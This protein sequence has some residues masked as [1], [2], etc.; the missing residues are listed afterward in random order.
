MRTF[1]FHDLSRL[2][3][4][5]FFRPEKLE[6]KCKEEIEQLV[7]EKHAEAIRQMAPTHENENVTLVEE[8]DWFWFFKK[9]VCCC[10]CLSI[11]ICLKTLF[12]LL[13]LYLSYT[14]LHSHSRIHL[15]TR[16]H[17]FSRCLKIINCV[18]TFLGSAQNLKS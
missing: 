12:K 9:Y 13:P 10:R 3:W 16:T 7:G 4:P 17:T 18:F 5:I 14:H 8:T 1:R 15:H 2:I 11:Y 6:I